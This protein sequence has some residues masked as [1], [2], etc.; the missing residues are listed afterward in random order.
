VGR[1]L[2]RALAGDPG[3][4]LIFTETRFA[5]AWV[6]ELEPIEDERGSFARTFDAGAWKDHGLNPAVV[7][8]NLS[9]NVRRGT[10]RGMH[11]QEQPYGECKLV[12]CTRGAIHDV[13]IDLRRESET[14]CSWFGI[15]LT[16]SNGKMLYISEGFAHGFQ[17]LAEATEVYYQMSQLYLPSHAR[18]VRWDDPAFAIE[19]PATE[20]RV[21]SER[22]RSYPDFRP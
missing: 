1:P 5:G 22:D 21:I 6:I 16:E 19:W 2:R 15:D 20:S 7:Q 17:T 8:C 14:F 11:Y 13:I 10:L 18:G 4:L 9:F 12:R 3:L